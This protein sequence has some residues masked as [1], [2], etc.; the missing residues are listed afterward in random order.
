MTES[1]ERFTAGAT[2]LEF[3]ATTQ[4]WFEAGGERKPI[5]AKKA[6]RLLAAAGLLVPQ[7]AMALSGGGYSGGGDVP[8]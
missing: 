2:T 5:S 6:V 1:T 8:T 7:A 3:D 4:T